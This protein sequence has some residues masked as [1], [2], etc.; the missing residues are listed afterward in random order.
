[1]LLL[2]KKTDYA[3]QCLIHLARHRRQWVSTAALS[4]EQQI[5]LFFLRRILRDLVR[6]G[7]VQ[8]REGKSGGLRLVVHPR[9]LTLRRIMHL[10]Q[11]KMLTAEC[12]FRKKICPRINCCALRPEIQKLQAKMINELNRVNVEKL[13]ANKGRKS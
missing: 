6:A 11:D 9:T 2:N 3:V 1:M 13:M 5:P 12:L 7:L 4:E 8:S 10:F